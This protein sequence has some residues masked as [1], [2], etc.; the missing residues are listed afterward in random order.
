MTN[1]IE[2]KTKN[3]GPK[4]KERIFYL[5]ILKCSDGSFYTGI[6]NDIKRR[7]EMHRSGK[8]SKYVAGRLPFKVVYTKR[9]GNRSEATKRELEIKSLDREGKMKLINE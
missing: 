2:S 7:M 9:I 3:E 6:T 4:T 1:N 5:Y 8:G